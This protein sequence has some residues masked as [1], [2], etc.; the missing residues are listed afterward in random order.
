MLG[1][2]DLMHIDNNRSQTPNSGNPLDSDTR[3]A[4]I[5]DAT[6]DVLLENIEHVRA[7]HASIEVV[8]KR[9]NHD[10][11]ATVGMR[12][13]LRM[14]Y[15][16]DE[17]VEVDTSPSPFFCRRYGV[18]LIGGVHGDMVKREDLPLIMAE[19]WKA[20]WAASSTR[21]WHTGHIH[22]D[23]LREFG[24]VGVYSHRAPVAQDAWHAA[25]GY[26]AGRSMRSFT[27]HAEKGF[28]VMSE[29]E[30]KADT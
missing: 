29:I 28:R 27:Y 24:S 16:K 8:L 14:F 3:Y 17:A 4:K 25:S 11:I 2:G 6:T 19:R 5:L 22:H 1:L 18:N 26:L 15:R 30:I 7:K 21:H 10:E 12:Q 20:D 23:T 9:G 13:A